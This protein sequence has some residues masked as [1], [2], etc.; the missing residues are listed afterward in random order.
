MKVKE[1]AENLGLEFSGD[2]DAEVLHVASI[3]D[4]GPGDL[5]FSEHPQLPAGSRPAC[6]ISKCAAASNEPAIIISE[7]PKLDFARAALLLIDPPV[8]SGSIHA[9]AQIGTGCKFGEVLIGPFVSIGDEAEIGDGVKILDGVRIG[10][11]VSIGADT[12]IHPNTVIYDG[13]RIGSNC[14]IHAGAV[15]GA[16]GFGFVRNGNDGWI[17]F[18]QIGSVIIGDEVEIGAGTCIDR[19]ALG[20]TKIGNGTKI[21]N[22]V[23][24]AHNVSIGE[25]V[26]IAS[27]TGISGSTVIEDDCIIGGQVGFGDHATVKS[28]AVIGSQAGVLP[29]K[30][31]RPGVWWGTP[32][33]PLDDYKKQ[34]ALVKG[35]GRLKEEVREL[36]RKLEE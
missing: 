8:F 5:A 15:I 1:I 21:D 34:N 36:K 29:G 20:D 19:G 16:D 30:I 28:G 27:Q 18:P 32:V 10:H 33:Q 25:R 22:L 3:S 9:S 13:V 35:I 17:K 24:V 4:A 14:I 7:N 12:V 11:R 2:G 23:Q 31:V 26:V 6:V